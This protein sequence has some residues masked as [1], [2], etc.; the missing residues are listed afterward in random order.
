M[1]IL[2]IIISLSGSG[3]NA[4]A[5]NTMLHLSNLSGAFPHTAT[6]PSFLDTSNPIMLSEN[7][8]PPSAS[9]V[10]LAPPKPIKSSATSQVEKLN[11][12]ILVC[13]IKVTIYDLVN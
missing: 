6:G 2:L 11:I 8:R 3:L 4:G 7:F 5:L 13:N 1:I 10:T 9:L 12:P